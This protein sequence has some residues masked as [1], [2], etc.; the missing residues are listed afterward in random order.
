[1]KEQATKAPTAMSRWPA[2]VVELERRIELLEVEA[3]YVVCGTIRAEALRQE[4]RRLTAR[5][6]AL[7]SAALAREVAA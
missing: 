1:V 5:L 3:S 4:A 7:K 6:E 2:E